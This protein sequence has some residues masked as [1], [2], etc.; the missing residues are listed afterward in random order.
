MK[1]IIS[2]LCLVSA[3]VFAYDSTLI[4][5]AIIKNASVSVSVNINGVKWA[6]NNK[7]ACKR[8]MQ[9]THDFMQNESR[10]ICLNSNG[11]IISR[12][13]CKNPMKFFGSFKSEPC[14]EY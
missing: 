5:T 2:V 13:T 12:F 6:E 1:K 10:G 4:F 8:A 9:N 14:K 11:E 3:P 7:I